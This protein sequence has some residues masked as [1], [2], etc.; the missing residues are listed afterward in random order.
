MIKNKISAIVFFLSSG[1]PQVF[2]AFLISAVFV[3]L[4]RVLSPIQLYGDELIQLEPAYR[5]SQGLG[6]T[7]N[8]YAS[9]NPALNQPL[10]P[11]FLT[12]FPPGFSLAVACLL[13]LKLSL[14]S[15]LK[16]I[17]GL[18]TIIGWISWAIIGSSMLYKP[19]IVFSRKLHINIV[20]ASIL[21]IF[22]T[23]VWS[24]SDIFLWAGTALTVVLITY[25]SHNI[26]TARNVN[27][28]RKKLLILSG[29]VVGI[30]YSFRYASIFLILVTF[31]ILLQANFPRIK[32]FLK[33][34]MLFLISFFSI[35]IPIFIY[36]KFFSNSGLAPYLLPND[37]KSSFLD[38]LIKTLN[39]LPG[40]LF[41]SN[42][43]ALSNYIFSLINSHKVI[44]IILGVLC[45]SCIFCLPVIAIREKNIQ[46]K[47][48]SEGKLSSD[49]NDNFS[50]NNFNNSVSRINFTVP[51][52][53]LPICLLTL[54][55]TSALLIR[56]D[57]GSNFG[58]LREARYYMPAGASII[59]FSYELLS[60]SFFSRFLKIIACSIIAIFISY[61]TIFYATKIFVSKDFSSLSRVVI[62]IDHVPNMGFPSNKVFYPIGRTQ[63]MTESLLK[64][65]KQLII[66]E[67][68]ALFFAENHTS[69]TY[70]NNPGSQNFRAIPEREFQSQ[71]DQSYLTARTKTFWIVHV[72]CSQGKIE[73]C[74]RS[75]SLVNI[76]SALPNQT[77]VFE[78]SGGAKVVFSELPSGF[79]FKDLLADKKAPSIHP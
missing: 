65:I 69:F 36:N 38:H 73:N 55:I 51:L 46:A 43:Y 56:G 77:T 79:R 67:P 28:N 74:A 66:A 7:S 41:M 4:V 42:L 44:S 25:S 60:F 24:G 63:T 61:N 3:V 48:R 58:F 72:S 52:S 33:D 68:Q 54:L 49:F 37:S 18:T 5:L 59:F 31:V 1:N 62:G 10:I 34:F 2:Y 17:F 45:L 16:I 30:T 9:F 75:D 22:N 35:F 76:V 8:Y 27:N 14:A 64:K 70:E 57:Y 47:I 11:Q 40:I 19:I 15:V 6:L 39:D 50:D 12:W 13:T 23:P 26:N 29:L 53:F 32:S 71:W 20:I 21:P 78:E